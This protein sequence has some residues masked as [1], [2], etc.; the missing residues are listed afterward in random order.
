MFS[1][2]LSF[3]IYK[4]KDINIR[5][6]MRDVHPVKLTMNHNEN[7]ATVIRDHYESSV[8]KIPQ[9]ASP[10]RRNLNARDPR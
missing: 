2:A 5:I 9:D 1:L 10:R 3:S 8:N 7:Y 4:K 6:E